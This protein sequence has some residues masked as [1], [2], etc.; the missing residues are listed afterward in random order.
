MVRG[1]AVLI[2]VALTAGCS[3]KYR[4]D[5]YE[6]PQGKLP[7][8]ASF[9]VSMPQDGSYGSE[10]YSGSGLMTA[11][12]AV[13]ALSHHVAKVRRANVVED[14]EVALAKAK[15]NDCRYLFEP[16]ILH[17]EERA[18]E[19]SGKPDRITL[20]MTVYEIPEGTVVASTVTRASSKWAT[21][22]GD[23][24]QDLLPVPMAN[25]V[26]GLFRAGDPKTPVISD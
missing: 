25:F 1:M 18:T 16:R 7:T 26:D 8:S 3:S 14:T 19:W 12:E 5:S 9:Y 15:S 4:V 6:G 13:T 10:Y 22:G 2:V 23:H 11:N 20:K 24:P 21:F 17:W